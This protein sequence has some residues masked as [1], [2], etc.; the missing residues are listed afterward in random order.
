MHG[1]GA[2]MAPWAFVYA[3]LGG[4]GRA[5]LTSGIELDAVMAHIGEQAGDVSEKAAIGA[6]G[7]GMFVGLVLLIKKARSGGSD[8]ALLDSQI[9]D[10]ETVNSGKE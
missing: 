8:P 1:R 5:L 9:T 3:S 2:G 4:A 7:L 6:L 10:R